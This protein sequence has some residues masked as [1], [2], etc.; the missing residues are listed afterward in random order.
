MKNTTPTTAYTK[1]SRLMVVAPYFYPKIGGLENYAYL[2]AKKL[3]TSGEYRVSIV[4][5]NYDGK[6]YKKE[7][8][9]GMTVHRLSI[10]FKI[11]NTPINPM[12]YWSLKRIMAIERPDMIHLHSPVPYLPDIAALLVKDIPM[13]LTYH[14]GS[15]LKNKWPI[16]I[17]VGLYENVFLYRLFKRADAIV[18]ISQEFAKRKFPQFI[19]KMHFIPTGVDLERF[20]Q[21]PLPTESE[22]VT[23][24][25]RIEHTSSWKGIEQLLQAFALVTHRRP[26]AIL[27]IVGGGDAVEH[28]CTRAREIGISERVVY[29]GPQVGQALVDAYERS[30]VVVLSSTSDS[31][32]FSVALV[33]AMACGRPII[34]T[35]IGGTPQVIEDGYNGLLVPP[36]DPA[37]LAEAIERVLTDRVLAVHLG[38]NGARKSRD[39]SWDIQAKQYD[40]LFQKI[41]KTDNPTI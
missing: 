8:I 26:R 22:I 27:E 1:S 10:W 28:Y 30:S 11:S 4:T 21:T 5:S 12:W 19:G 25:G 35:N 37:K 18:A 14:S 9:D 31:E 3:H 40:D 29:A 33:E 16:D 24:V 23:F 34:G 38:D 32:A 36:K 13:V 15:M 7:V 6:G 41:L 17:L 20:K 2:L 39:F